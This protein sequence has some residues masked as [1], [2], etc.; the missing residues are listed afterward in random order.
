MRLF[1]ACCGAPELLEL[2]EATLNEITL[3]IEMLVQRVFERARRGV[4]DDGGRPLGGDRLERP[5]PFRVFTG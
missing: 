1:E 3:C 4:R 5:R 2:A